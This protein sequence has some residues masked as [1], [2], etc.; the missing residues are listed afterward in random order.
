MIMQ[1]LMKALPWLAGLTAVLHTVWGT[2]EVHTP[3]LTSELPP[4]ISLLLYA[5]WHIVTAVLI[6]SSVVL[7]VAIYGPKSAAWIIAARLVGALWITSGLVFISITLLF[8]DYTKLFTLG[9]WILLIPIG[10]L[11]LLGPYQRKLNRV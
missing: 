10:L 4:E 7:M 5:C 8:S 11:T 2:S 6:G 3:L 1:F 9:Q